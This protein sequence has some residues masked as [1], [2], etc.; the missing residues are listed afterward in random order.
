MYYQPA[1]ANSAVDVILTSN[2]S[3]NRQFVCSPRGI[4]IFILFWKRSF[5]FIKSFQLVVGRVFVQI[6]NDSTQWLW[7]VYRT[8]VKAITAL[9]IEHERLSILFSRTSDLESPITFRTVETMLRAIVARRYLR[10]SRA[11]FNLDNRLSTSPTFDT[12]T[13]GAK[14][15]LSQVVPI[16]IIFKPLSFSATT[17]L[18]WHQLETMCSPSEK[19]GQKGEKPIAQGQS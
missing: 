14:V 6:A 11:E 7:L 10:T 15:E 8:S 17:I 2:S 19:L 5:T 3:E 18:N 9:T 13:F 12:L 1:F 16:I 4:T